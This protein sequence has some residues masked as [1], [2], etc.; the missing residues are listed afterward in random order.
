MRI[1]IVILMLILNRVRIQVEF[2]SP[3]FIT[4]VV[5]PYC[6]RVRQ[7][8]T[9]QNESV[10]SVFACQ[11]LVRRKSMMLQSTRDSQVSAHADSN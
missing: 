3:P 5:P 1:R 6:F 7:E 4:N 11:C 9:S 2:H 8:G 10:L